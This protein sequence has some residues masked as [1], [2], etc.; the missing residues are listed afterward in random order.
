MDLLKVK[1]TL[2]KANKKAFKKNPEGFV[3]KLA[4]CLFLL[5]LRVFV[6]ELIDTT[7]R[8]N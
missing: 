7:S 4:R 2:I 6:L 5:K 8:I 1:S 3:Y